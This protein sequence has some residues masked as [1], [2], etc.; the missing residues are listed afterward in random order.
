MGLHPGDP[1][2]YIDSTQQTRENITDCQPCCTLNHFFLSVCLLVRSGRWCYSRFLLSSLRCLF[3]IFFLLRRSRFAIDNEPPVKAF[4]S[5]RH[6]FLYFQSYKPAFCNSIPHILPVIS[7]C[8]N[9]ESESLRFRDKGIN[10]IGEAFKVSCLD[11]N[12]STA[13]KLISR[14]LRQS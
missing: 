4:D 12:S 9:A 14:R 13:M 11:I 2:N 1:R 8:Y 6:L 10:M 7:P 5:A 3:F